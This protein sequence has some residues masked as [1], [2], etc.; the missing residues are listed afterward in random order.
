M[1][2]L[3]QRLASR[4]DAYSLRER[5]LVAL[6]LIGGTLLVGL[7]AFVDPVSTRNRVARQNIE[8]QVS[9]LAAAQAQLTTLEAQVRNDPDAARK[10]EI[11]N[12]QNNLQQLGQ[13]LQAA[14]SGLLP[15]ERMN[16]VLESL[17]KRHPGVHLASLKTLKP[18]SIFPAT[19]AKGDG[20]AE[21]PAR[22]FDIYR[23]GVEIRLEGSYNDLHAYL[24]NLDQE[25]KKLLW[26]EARLSVEEHPRALLTVVLYTLSSDKAWLAL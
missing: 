15:P 13:R 11:Q 18:V 10:A 20:K 4:F 12:L 17:L 24:A 26:G 16:A 21:P 1:K 25:Q 7:S 3:W 6:A 14:E 2:A 23:H 5:A 9:E 22:D 8:R 19:P